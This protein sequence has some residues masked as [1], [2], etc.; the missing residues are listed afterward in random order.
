MGV[1]APVVMS[2]TT[3]AGSAQF[4]A[5]S[6]LGAGGGIAAAVVAALLLNARYTPIGLSVAHAIPGRGW[7]RF[8]RSQLIVDESWAIATTP[9]GVDGRRL[10]GAGLVMFAAWVG[11]T[12]VGVLGAEALGDPQTFGLDAAFPAVFLALLAPLLR[13]HRSVAAA[14]AGALIALA[15]LPWAPAGV[16]VI[17]ATAG[18]LVGWRAPR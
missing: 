1:V 15:F 17:A 9:H 2:A 12:V 18:V 3:F 6:V 10:M 13:S 5:V 4:A 8:L 7:R 11:G 16:P 14:S